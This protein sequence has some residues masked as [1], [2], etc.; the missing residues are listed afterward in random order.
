MVC[1]EQKMKLTFKIWILIFF[2]SLSLIS[3]FGLPPVFLEKGVLITSVGENSSFFEQGIRQGQIIKQIDEIKIN[4]VQDYSKI[5]QEKFPSEIEVRTIFVTN[6]GQYIFFEKDM[7]EITL[8]EVPNTRVKAG[9]DISGGSRALIR[10]KEGEMSAVELDDLVETT[11]NRFNEFGLS[12]I[13]VGPVTDLSGKRFMLIELAG[14][15][16]RDLE[17]LI[18]EQGVFEARIG[19]QTV[20]SG[21]EGD[22]ASVSRS[23]QTSG[24]YSCQKQGEAEFCNFRFGVFLTE[25]A[26]EKHAKITSQIEI[27]QSNPEYLSEKLDL[28]LDG[29]LVNSLLIGKDLK[30]SATTQ[31]SISGSGSGLTRQEAIKN[32]QEEMKQLQTVLITGSLPFELEIVKLDTISP[33]L[34][35][36]FIRAIL[37]AGLAALLAV[38]LVVFLRYRKIYSSFALILTSMCEVTIILGI[39][40]F[41][42][43]NLD[44]PSI[45]G[46]IAGVGTG[47]DSQLIVLDE[48]RQGENLSLKEKLRRAFKIILGAYFTALVALLPLIWAGAGLLK[49]FAIT[50]IIG[51]SVG[52][53]ITRPAFTDMIRFIEE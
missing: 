38:G 33:N 17:R 28:Y 45:A 18:S 9:L 43:W 19:N 46:I 47:I 6:M 22:I 48:A 10:A 35:K 41:I 20:F 12:D 40:S 44:L 52:V 21:G 31:I 14:A 29:K 37:L 16:P 4:S 3:L 2:V 53:L 36:D 25:A 42:G 23:G 11:R 27:N 13:N 1:G 5:I 24:I 49:G 15:T 34:G 50:T 8:A 32:T 51:I 39:A 7:P 30:G 26:A